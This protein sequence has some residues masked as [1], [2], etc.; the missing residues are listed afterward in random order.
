MTAL[1]EELKK[2]NEELLTYVERLS[3]MEGELKRK[4]KELEPSRGI[5]A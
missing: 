1:R 3:A 5:E 2:K 4:D